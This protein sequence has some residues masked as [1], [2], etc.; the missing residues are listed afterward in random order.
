VKPLEEHVLHKRKSDLFYFTNL[1]R[2]FDVSKG[3]GSEGREGVQREGIEDKGGR[4]R[5]MVTAGSVTLL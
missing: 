3:E 1:S 2:N 5:E 4:Q